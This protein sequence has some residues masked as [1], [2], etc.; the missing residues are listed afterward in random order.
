MKNQKQRNIKELLEVMLNNQHLFSSG[1]CQWVVS[2]HLY[3]QI[4]EG[5]WRT[6]DT[7]IQ[8]NK[9]RGAINKFLISFRG[10]FYWKKGNI[11]PRIKWIK[12]HLKNLKKNTIKFYIKL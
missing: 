10:G 7:Y 11:K 5:E 9:P 8:K 3:D 2:C 4:S 1:L 6:L 12:K